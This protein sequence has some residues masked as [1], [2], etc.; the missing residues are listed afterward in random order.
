MDYDRWKTTNPW[1]REIPSDV[2][3]MLGASVLIDDVR[4]T[5]VDWE[6]ECDEDE[7]GKH[8]SITYEIESD[9]GTF[10]ADEYAVQDALA[11]AKKTTEGNR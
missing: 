8:R 2:E 5:I 7:D 9:D 1:E 3:D 11:D 6:E 10:W 4:G